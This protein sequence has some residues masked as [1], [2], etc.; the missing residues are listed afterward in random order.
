VSQ[1]SVAQ[2]LGCPSNLR[3][4]CQQSR[5]SQQSH[6]WVW[7]SHA[8]CIFRRTREPGPISNNTHSAGHRIQQRSMSSGRQERASNTHSAQDTS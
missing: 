8:G 6:I 7:A 4:Q 1:T 2:Y 5:R 3:G